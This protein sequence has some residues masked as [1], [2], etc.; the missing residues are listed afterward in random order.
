MTTED[1]RKNYPEVA[2][3]VDEFRA[4]GIQVK[5][6]KLYQ[7]KPVEKGYSIIRPD[8]TAV[9]DLVFATQADADKYLERLVSMGWCKNG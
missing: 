2:K 7:V 8:K 9:N 4:E 5:V 3:L 6:L 1:N